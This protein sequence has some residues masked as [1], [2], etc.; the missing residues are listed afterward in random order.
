M[1]KDTLTFER[2]TQNKKF[3]AVS[4]T[5]WFCCQKRKVK[6]SF[7]GNAFAVRDI[8]IQINLLYS[9]HH[10]FVPGVVKKVVFRPPGTWNIFPRSGG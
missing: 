4:K 9:S 7:S 5:N 3:K 10:L 2:K 6:V 1:L 8:E